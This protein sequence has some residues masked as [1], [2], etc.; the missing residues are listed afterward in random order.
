MSLSACER[1]SEGERDQLEASPMENVQNVSV[2]GCCFPVS[3][4]WCSRIWLSTINMQKPKFRWTPP[5]TSL[6]Y[7]QSNKTKPKPF[8]VNGYFPP[9]PHCKHYS[10]LVR[11][12]RAAWGGGNVCKMEILPLNRILQH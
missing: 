5:P 3:P 7:L 2:A 6:D 1:K 9:A 10:H 11:G 4:S 12:V 8:P